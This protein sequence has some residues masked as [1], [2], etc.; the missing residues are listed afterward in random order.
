MGLKKN[1][2]IVAIPNKLYQGLMER[3]QIPFFK[4]TVLFL[5]DSPSKKATSCF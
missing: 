4:S 3:E 5:S 1:V 2:M